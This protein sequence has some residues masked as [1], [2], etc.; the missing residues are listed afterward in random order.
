MTDKTLR[1]LCKDGIWSLE[2]ILVLVCQVVIVFPF[3]TLNYQGRFRKDRRLSSFRV[4]FGQGGVKKDSVARETATVFSLETQTRI[5]IQIKS[6]FFF[7]FWY[8]ADDFPKWDF[9]IYHDRKICYEFLTTD[10]EKMNIFFSNWL[11]LNLILE[12]EVKFWGRCY[13]EWYIKWK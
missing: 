12:G 10:C 5:V 8:N 9:G 7:L 13:I 6:F 3:T 1:V 11:L 2:F 4:R